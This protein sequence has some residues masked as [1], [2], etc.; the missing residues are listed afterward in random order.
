MPLI[1]DL[2][3][4]IDDAI[5]DFEKVLPGIEKQVAG[6]L[7]RLFSELETRNGFLKP[8]VKN[9]RTVQRLKNKI[10]DAIVNKSYT[11]NVDDLLKSY[12]TISG[13][14]DKY[15][16]TIATTFTKPAVLNEI[17]K[18]ARINTI[19]S[20]TGAGI[21][22]QLVQQVLD[23]ALNNVKSASSFVDLRDELEVFIRGAKDLPGKLTSYSG[24]I[25]RD[26]INQFSASYAETVAADLG[27]K[28]Y[29]YVGTKVADSR[30]WCVQMV[31]KKWVHESELP[32][33]IKGTVNGKRVRIYD[34]TG[35]PQ[36]MI[37]GT[38]AKN[39]KIRRGG[40][41]CMHQLVPVATLS[42]PKS[43]RDKIS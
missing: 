11:A 1:Q 19:E 29:Q 13:I 22:G 31:K 9:L 23:K 24:L 10:Y 7:S 43:V 35:L 38:N 16:A 28:W 8:T 2:L 5:I 33:L 4:E 34:R 17:N 36:G 41:N 12:S 6:E 18:L 25:V 42:V 15:F 32:K 37:A 39:V 14:Q 40:W 27:L 26:S 20:L 3:N 30:E 21:E